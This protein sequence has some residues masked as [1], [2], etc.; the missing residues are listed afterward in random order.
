MSDE[1]Q[2]MQR[3][4]EQR[5]RAKESL[6]PRIEDYLTSKGLPLNKPFLCLNPEHGDRS[7]SMSYDRVRYRAHCFSCEASYDIFDLVGIEY[8]LTEYNDKLEKVASMYGYPLHGGGQVYRKQVGNEQNTHSDI[9]TPAPAQPEKKDYSRMY[10]EAHK[11][12]SETSYLKLRGLSAE[13]ME[14]FNLGYMPEYMV[15]DHTGELAKWPVVIVPT[16]EYSYVVRNV[17][18]D[19][20][21]KDRYR[22]KGE[23]H[24]LNADALREAQ[25]PIFVVEGE[26]DAMSIVEAGGAAVGLGSYD[27]VPLFLKA[28]EKDKPTQ[29]IVVAFDN[30]T[31]PDKAKRVEEATKRLEEGLNKLRIRHCRRSPQGAYKDANEALVKDRA[32]FVEAV[33]AVANDIGQVIAQEAEEAE[34]K[35]KEAYL[36]QNQVSNHLNAFIDG[37]A[38]SVN[39]PCTPTGFFSLDT[40]LDGG[41]YEGLYTIGAISSLGKTTLILQIGDQIAA[42]GKDVIIFSLEM[43]RSELMAK[44]ISRH[45]ILLA[46][47][48]NLDTK[49]AKTARGIMDGKRYANY[50]STETQLIKDS[51]TAYSKYAEHLYIQ[52]GAGEVGVAQIR[53]TV[54]AHLRY[55]GQRPV[56]IVDYLQILSPYSERLSDKQNTDKAV[57]ELKRISRDYKIPVLAISSFNRMSYNESVTMEA[58]KESGAI[59]YSSDVLFGL[60]LRGAGTKDFN[61][62]EA[63][64]KNPRQIELV[65]LKNRSGRVGDNITFSYYPLFNYYKEV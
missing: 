32:A 2:A 46:D 42:S 54:E 31:D 57:L 12:L 44:S 35:A 13:T 25:T 20:D 29:P 15:R 22:K 17:S 26:L 21:H 38:E 27:N 65:I 37:I 6:K 59:E 16:S 49:N 51:I 3:A 36:Q 48:R 24:L 9:H 40:A 50:N 64:K 33:R 14:R 10:A 5:E 58:F 53:E 47:E 41:L 45:S 28:A 19:A 7:P 4:M 8:G 39:T 43:A 23:S 34:Q 62:T 30:E 11:R 60:Q 18:P 61:P 63:K 56:V 1:V 55:T 52:E